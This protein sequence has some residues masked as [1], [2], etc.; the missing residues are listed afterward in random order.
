MY[1]LIC[2]SYT[3]RTRDS[4]AGLADRLQVAWTIQ[5]KR[6]HFQKIVEHL[7][8]RAKRIEKRT[9][10]NARHPTTAQALKHARADVGI[11]EQSV[12]DNLVDIVKAD[13]LLF[14][15]QFERLHIEHRDLT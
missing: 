4:C 1:A 9:P 6:Q 7:D 14:T 3:T 10:D 11:V 13:H 15:D 12:L 8:I 5:S 2:F